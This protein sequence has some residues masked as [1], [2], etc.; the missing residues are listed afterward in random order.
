MSDQ[1]FLSEASLEQLFLEI[2]RRHDHAIL[3]TVSNA[4]S[5]NEK[6]RMF[7]AGGIFP[8]IGLARCFQTEVIKT[9]LDANQI[10]NPEDKP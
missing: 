3:A 2:A 5:D 8:A 4:A 6:F 10:K 7:H 1:P 9:V